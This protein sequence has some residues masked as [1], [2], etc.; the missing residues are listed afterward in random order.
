[1]K[2]FLFILVILIV[3][4]SCQHDPTGM[5][6]KYLIPKKKFVNIL[7]DIHIQDAV[8]GSPYFTQ[9][10]SRNDSINVYQSIFDKYNVTQQEFDSTITSYTRRPDLYAEVYDQVILRLNL[11]IDQLKDNEPVFENPKEDQ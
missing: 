5:N 4:I 8:V 7:V 10:Y 1:M 2:K 3:S 9:N 6:R 11:K